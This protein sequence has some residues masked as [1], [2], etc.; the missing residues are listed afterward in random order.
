MAGVGVSERG[1]FSHSASLTG[2]KQ[3]LASP[4]DA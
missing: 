3:A 1:P 2:D 4:W